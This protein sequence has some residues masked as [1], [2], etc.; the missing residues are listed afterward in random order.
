MMLQ[1]NLKKIRLQQKAMLKYLRFPSFLV[2]I[3][4]LSAAV[5]AQSGGVKG[6]VRDQRGKG[7]ANAQ[8]EVRKDGNVIKS[9]NSKASFK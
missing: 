5:F 1:P 8:V 3:L 6:K 4:L 9:T 7:I 2:G